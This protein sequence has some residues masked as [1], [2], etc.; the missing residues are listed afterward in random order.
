VPLLQHEQ[1][2]GTIIH[3]RS[4][5]SSPSWALSEPNVFLSDYE[6]LQAPQAMLEL[7][8]AIEAAGLRKRWYLLSARRQRARA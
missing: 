7:A 8:D 1:G 5:T 6:P 2:R 3:R 4:P